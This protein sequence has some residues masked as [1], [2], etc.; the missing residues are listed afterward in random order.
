[1]L[2]PENGNGNMATYRNWKDVSPGWRYIVMAAY[3]QQI[4]ISDSREKLF[5]TVRNASI[6][7]ESILRG[8]A[9]AGRRL[10]TCLAVFVQGRSRNDLRGVFVPFKGIGVFDGLLMAFFASLMVFWWQDE[11]KAIKKQAG[12]VQLVNVGSFVFWWRRSLLLSL[13]VLSD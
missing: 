3:R 10:H 4:S 7:L 6:F 12:R 9:G 5:L 1:M 8:L 13:D 11:S 2:P